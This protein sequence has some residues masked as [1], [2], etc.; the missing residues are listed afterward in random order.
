MPFP[1]IPILSAAAPLL[2]GL[3]GGKKSKQA[4]D[5]RSQGATLQDLLPQI[6]PL[7]QQMQAQNQERYGV[8]MQRFQSQQ[9]LHDA[10]SRMA[11]GLLPNRYTSGLPMPTPLSVPEVAPKPK[12]LPLPTPQAAPRQPSGIRG[13]VKE[14]MARARET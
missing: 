13:T 10:L 1:L 14:M 2:T 11:F 4:A 5:K 9:P 7:L 8:Q 6:L 3:F 12:P